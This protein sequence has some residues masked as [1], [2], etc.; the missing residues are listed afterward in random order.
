MRTQKSGLLVNLYQYSDSILVAGCQR[1]G[2]T[3]ISRLLTQGGRL[4]NFWISHDE[5]LDAALIL[6]G[7][8]HADRSRRYCFQT[9]YLND[10]YV[11][12]FEQQ[13][14]FKLVWVLR[15]PRSVIYSMLYNW[16]RYAFNEL[17]DACGIHFDRHIQD[18]ESEKLLRRVEK[19][20]ASYNAKISQMHEIG[21]RL[22]AECLLVVDYDSLVMAPKTHLPILFDFAKLKYESSYC[23]LI[24]SS[25]TNK[26]NRLGDAETN[27]I[28]VQCADAYLSACKKLLDP[29]KQWDNL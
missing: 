27:I 20:C 7:R 24:H 4:G 15:N 12:Y 9:T 14:E 6:A 18:E 19:A 21:S 17:Y 25:S 5:E 8:E 16:D 29:A 2:T 22:S 28:D 11:E 10:R 13:K 3:A 1:S 23:D 26:A